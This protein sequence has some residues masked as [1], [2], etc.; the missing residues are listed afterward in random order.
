VPIVGPDRLDTVV[1]RLLEGGVVAIP[2]DTVYG[3][4]TRADDNS[5]VAQLAELKGR[6]ANQ[7]I[8]VLFD[9]VDVIQGKIEANEGFESLA[10]HWPGALTLI[11]GAQPSAFASLLTPNGTIGI[12]QPDDDLARQV[13]ARCGGVLAVTSANRHGEP[14][15]ASAE[16]AA[17]IFGDELL[18]LDGG[19]RGEV[20]STV[21]DLSVD[22]PRVLREGPLT[23][24]DLGL[25]SRNAL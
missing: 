21:V 15:A 13:I 5:A 18:I 19:P 4:A 14:A 8:A 24:A 2:T 20:A 9:E 22:P 23:A 12:R 6:D 3:L 16:A 7:P 17:A 25:T 1:Q 11:I 10:R